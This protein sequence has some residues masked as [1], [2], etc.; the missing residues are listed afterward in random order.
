MPRARFAPAVKS[1]SQP[2]VTHASSR[3]DRTHR[4][5]EF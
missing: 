2:E 5:S 1:P 3:Q 4:T